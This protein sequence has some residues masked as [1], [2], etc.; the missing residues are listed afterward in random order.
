MKLPNNSAVPRFGLG[1][2]GT[3]ER[4]L[5]APR[6][7]AQAAKAQVIGIPRDQWAVVESAQGELSVA[8][9]FAGKA[10][11]ELRLLGIDEPLLHQAL[12]RLVG[13]KGQLTLAPKREVAHAPQGDEKFLRGLLTRKPRPNKELLHLARKRLPFIFGHVKPRSRK[14][15]H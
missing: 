11:R 12:T 13:K 8:K 1:G 3:Y 5:A 9:G 15:L 2:V 14:T 10:A 4:V 7:L 6:H